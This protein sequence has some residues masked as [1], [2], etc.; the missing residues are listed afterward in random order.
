[1]NDSQFPVMISG[2]AIFMRRISS[3]AQSVL[4]IAAVLGIAAL[5]GCRT[6]NSSGAEATTI[7]QAAFAG[8]DSN[9]DGKLSQ[10]ELAGH[11]HK[12][13]LAEFD[14]NEDNHISAQEWALAKPSAGDDDPFFN[15]LDKDSDGT[16]AREEAILYITEHVQF[17]DSFSDL[18]RNGDFH[19]HWE[20]F[21]ANEP[22]SVRFVL[23]SV[24]E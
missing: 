1:M 8:A 5:P 3:I 17:G 15:R 4:C 21:T 14:L 11:L 18:D 12:E 10:E 24:K 13:A 9:A 6:M 2:I 22:A 19:L 7:D 23:F 20:E 16:V